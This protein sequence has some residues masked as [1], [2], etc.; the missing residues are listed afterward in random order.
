MSPEQL[1]GQNIDSRGDIW[2]FGVVLYELVTG[3]RPFEGSTPTDEIASILKSE[4]ADIQALG[5]GLPRDLTTIM[6]KCLEKDADARYQSIEQVLADLKTI[7]QRLESGRE[8]SP[9]AQQKPITSARFS[10]RR[11]ALLAMLVAAVAILL[12]GLAYLKKTFTHT[13]VNS[14]AV[15][16]FRNTSSDPELEYLSDGLSESVIN[17]L[18]QL[19]A[20]KVIS[21][22]STSKYNTDAVDLSQVVR[23]VG[24]EAIVVGRIT[25]VGADLQISAE[26]VDARDH[27]RMWGR[28][29]RRSADGWVAVQNEIAEEIAHKLRTNLSRD[30]SQKLTRLETVNPLAFE[31]LLRGRHTW[32][33]GGTENWKKAIQYY[34]QAIVLDPHYALAYANLAGSYKSLIGNSLLDPGEF[35]QAADA[36]VK[37]ALELDDSLA[38]A[39]Y[40]LASMKTDAWDWAG[41]EHE[42]K[43]AIELNP[44]LAAA[45]NAYS[46]FLSVMGRHDESIAAIQRARELD[47][48]SLIIHANMGYRLYF[49]RRYDEAIQSLR[50]TLDRQ[51]D[52]ALA[53]ILLGYT[54]AAKKMHSEAIASYQ[55]AIK[56]GGDTPGTNIY[57]AASYAQTGE[58][59]KAKTILQRL[60]SAKAYISPG[61][62]SLLH[63]ALG[64]KQ[65]AFALL[66]QAYN[67]HDLQLQYL[68]ADPAFDVLRDDSRFRELLRRVGLNT[69]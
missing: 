29:F 50:S 26:L 39:H 54:Y 55:Q 10:G 37:R 1:R 21:R 2:S 15:L 58:V 4:P 36:A 45:H 34:Q 11:R 57:M 18:S 35:R 32:R 12:L 56:S 68:G 48:S 51:R 61:E 30:Q 33:K 49:A 41:A 23:E 16:P 52:Y 65:Q 8:S 31:M 24:V 67:A 63:A 13:D 19:P 69:S 38:D 44:N 42:F 5:S 27:T 20:L 14:I 9:S 62:L 17:K 60:H 46:A 53:H 28:Q 7:R 43:R 47:P 22:S 64:D 66:E 40:T 59:E 6:G 3:R 25:Q